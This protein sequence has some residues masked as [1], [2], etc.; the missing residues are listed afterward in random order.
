MKKFIEAMTEV[1]KK[2]FTVNGEKWTVSSAKKFT[3]TSPKGIW[4]I[5]TNG[6]EFKTIYK[7]DVLK[8]DSAKA[9]A[10]FN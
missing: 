4:T 10:L 2:G 6:K 1:S 9:I 7:A 8:I 5:F 3:G